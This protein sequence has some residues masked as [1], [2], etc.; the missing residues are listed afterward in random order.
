MTQT[1]KC[2][3][4]PSQWLIFTV[5]RWSIIGRVYSG[6]PAINMLERR[7]PEGWARGG[8][9]RPRPACA[10]RCLCSPSFLAR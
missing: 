2:A 9:G 3:T 4:H 5:S 6:K 7:D 1:R 8:A 10:R